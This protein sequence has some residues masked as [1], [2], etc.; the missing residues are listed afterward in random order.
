MLEYLENILTLDIGKPLVLYYRAI[1]VPSIFAMRLR[2]LFICLLTYLFTACNNPPR[3]QVSTVAGTGV[4]G[5]VDGSAASASFANLASLA[6]DT[7]GNIYIA[8]AFNNSI[9][10]LSKDGQ[11]TTVAGSGAQGDADGAVSQASFFYPLG[12]AIDNKG[13]IYVADTRNSLIRKISGGFVTTIAGKS[14]H[15]PL[16]VKSTVQLDNPSGIVVGPTGDIFFSDWGND[17]IRKI[18]TTGAVSVYAGR[19]SPGLVDG[20]ADT[21]AFYLPWGLTADSAGN[22]YVADC[23]N[24]AIRKIS[25]NGLVTTVAGHTK[26]GKVNGKGTVASFHKPAALYIN[27]NHILYVADAGNN[28]VRRIAEDGTVSTLAGSGKRGN[29][30]GPDTLASFFK[31]SGITA[32]KNGVIYIADFD[33]NIIRA[34]HHP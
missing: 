20:H 15:H 26:K 8:D 10:K 2:H 9:R 31:P 13:D 16:P 30:D 14:I 17:V 5:H 28:L 11:V 34:I 25:T 29:E 6:T 22:L 33:N 24:N 4:I 3:V 7:A 23:Y 12:I 32:G 21:A 27:N 19:G 18:D 1:P